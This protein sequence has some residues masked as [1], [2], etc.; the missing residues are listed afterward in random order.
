MTNW[1]SIIG[2]PG[3]SAPP[4]VHQLHGSRRARRPNRNPSPDGALS[5]LHERPVKP[6]LDPAMAL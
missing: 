2:V 3:G 5:P 6:Q 1:R 4:I